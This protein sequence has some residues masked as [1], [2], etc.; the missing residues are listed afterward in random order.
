MSVSVCKFLKE[1][2]A[3]LSP[4]NLLKVDLS[5]SAILPLKRIILG[6]RVDRLLTS[7][8]LTA[9]SP[10]LKPFMESVIRFYVKSTSVMIKY[11]E[12]LII[13]KI[14]RSL[15][16][17]HPAEKSKSVAEARETWKYL[18]ES[19]P[20]IVS[21]EELNHI[22]V[23]ELPRYAGLEDPEE[24]ISI[25]EWW[26]RVAEVDISGEKYFE[27]LTRLALGL[28]TI[29][30]SSSEAERDISK[31]NQ[32]F[33]GD[34]KSKISQSTVQDRMIVLASTSE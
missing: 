30:N 5:E 8:K 1:N 31:L 19:F 2:V 26:A 14:L 7:V 23:S 25:D 22:L 34:K 6:T 11:F 9:E 17:L 3:I 4:R 13:S 15:S 18:G 27:H 24:G 33:S 28:C 12:A 10:E 32:I 21:E 16:I 20:N 29:Y